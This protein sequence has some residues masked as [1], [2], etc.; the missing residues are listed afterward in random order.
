MCQ[1][2]IEMQVIIPKTELILLS[3]V[4][5]LH[6]AWV[7]VSFCEKLLILVMRNKVKIMTLS[8]GG[9]ARPQVRLHTCVSNSQPNF[10][11]RGDDPS[12]LVGQ[13]G[14]E[15]KDPLSEDLACWNLNCSPGH[16]P[17]LLCL[18]ADSEHHWHL[19]S[20][21]VWRRCCSNFAVRGNDRERTL[22]RSPPGWWENARLYLFHPPAPRHTAL[23]TDVWVCLVISQIRCHHRYNMRRTWPISPVCPLHILSCGLGQPPGVTPHSSWGNNSKS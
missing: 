5:R 11:G 10:L 23:C 9:S 8:Y 2:H 12:S 4:P 16:N 19:S 18:F 14:L 7:E 3:K 20:A 21:T 17:T 1:Y 6:W 22:S 13:S 15:N